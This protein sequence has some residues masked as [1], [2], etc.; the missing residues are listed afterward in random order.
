MECATWIDCMKKYPKAFEHG[1]LGMWCEDFKCVPS[2][3]HFKNR[4]SKTSC[5]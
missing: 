1:E 5:I 4:K 2:T 3:F